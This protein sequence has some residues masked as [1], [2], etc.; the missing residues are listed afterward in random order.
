MKEKLWFTGKVYKVTPITTTITKKKLEVNNPTMIALFV[1][2]M[3]MLLL[4]AINP[5]RI[6]HISIEL[7]ENSSGVIEITNLTLTVYEIDTYLRGFCTMASDC[8]H[9]LSLKGCSYD[10]CNYHCCQG[11]HCTTTSMFCFTSNDTSISSWLKNVTL[12]V[13]D[14]NVS[15]IEGGLK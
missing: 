10:G 7:N 13:V 9:N 15:A 2:A 8:F 3:C 6:V 12:D 5:Q 4:P 1:L 14:L 11:S